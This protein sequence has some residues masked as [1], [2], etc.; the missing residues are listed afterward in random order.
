MKQ[1]VIL[2][3]VLLL[4]SC[5]TPGGGSNKNAFG[6]TK[7]AYQ[8]AEREFK[9]GR[10]SQ[11]SKRLQAIH[12]DHP[13]YAKA[14]SFLTKT[15]HPA[16]K[17][18][19]RY[20]QKKARKAERAKQWFSAWQQYQQLAD[21][22]EAEKDADKVT[23][24]HLSLREQRV[25]QLDTQLQLEDKQ[26]LAWL[27]RYQPGRGLDANDPAFQTF[28]ADIQRLIQQ[29]VQQKLKLAKSMQK[30]K[31]VELA[32]ILLRSA[33][34]LQADS[35][36]AEKL[37]SLQAKLPKGFYLAAK[38]TSKKRARAQKRSNNG[39]ATY[40]AKVKTL[41]QQ[42]QWLKASKYQGKL[43]NSGKKGMD[44]LH[45]IQA[46]S[47]QAASGLFAKGR[48]SFAGEKIDEAVRLWQRAVALV[49]TNRDYKQAL[50]RAK[51]VQERLRLIRAQQ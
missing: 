25:R 13:D 50:L 27:K 23:A 30:E 21:L 12:Q 22:S 39:E 43:R 3:C 24:M 32:Y 26:T 6:S 18:L 42:K 41:V 8:H 28:R 37:I 4:A 31:Q 46:G 14:Q 36:S 40:L 47:K 49:P 11:A 35:V 48:E 33:Q 5:A 2:C 44:L 10:V 16:S 15:V 1:L 7:N 51:Q 19:Q 38:R 45:T 34:R 20:H 29:R 9:A 17:R